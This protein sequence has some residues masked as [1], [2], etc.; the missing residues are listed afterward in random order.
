MVFSRFNE[1]FIV[2]RP[3]TYKWAATLLFEAILPSQGHV[4]CTP[5]KQNTD[6]PS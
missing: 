3:N 1:N 5:S 4:A 6:A 2:T